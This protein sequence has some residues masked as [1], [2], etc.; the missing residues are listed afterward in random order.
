MK[1][2]SYLLLPL[3]LLASFKSS[4]GP[5][6]DKERKD[7][8]DLLS[9]TEQGVFDVVKGLSEAQLNYKAAPDRWNDL[10]CGVFGG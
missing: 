10:F 1:K 3:L 5:L 6:T 7:A 2:L 9:K 4:N 8:I